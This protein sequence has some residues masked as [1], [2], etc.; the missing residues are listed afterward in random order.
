[1]KRRSQMYDLSEDLKEYQNQLKEGQI[2]R[3][4]KGIMKFMTKL[5]SRLK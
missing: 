5:A 4:Y 1:M 2:Q 3:A